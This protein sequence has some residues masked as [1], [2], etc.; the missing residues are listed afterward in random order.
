VRYGPLTASE[1]Y[2]RATLDLADW[3]SIRLLLR[4]LE[5]RGLLERHRALGGAFLGSGPYN[6]HIWAVRLS[7][8]PQD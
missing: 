1:V 6:A 2:E 8:P 3:R 5:Q 7:P 4:S